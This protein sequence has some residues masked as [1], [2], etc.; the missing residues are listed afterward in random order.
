MGRDLAFGMRLLRR[1][2]GFAAISALGALNDWVF[3][4]AEV[5]LVL[6]ERGVFPRFFARVNKAGMPVFGHVLGCTLSVAVSET[7]PP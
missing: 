6:A 7:V 1:A 5:P 2:T 4:Q 3:L